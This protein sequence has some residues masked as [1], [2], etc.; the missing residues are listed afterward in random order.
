MINIKEE[1][2][3]LAKVEDFYSNNDT[4]VRSNFM[5]SSKYRSTLFSNR[6]MAISLSRLDH[7]KESSDGYLTVT[8]KGK[9]IQNML[10]V[11]SNNFFKELSKTAQG[12]TGQTIGWSSPETQEFEY[13]AV[14]TKATFKDGEF[15]VDFHKDIKHFLKDLKNSYTKLSLSVMLSFKS[16]YSFRLYELLRSKAYYKKGDERGDNLFKIEFDTNELRLDLGVVNAE[17]ESVRRV[18]NGKRGSDPEMWE[19][20]VAAS[21]EKTYSSWKDFKRFVLDKAVAEINDKPE[22]GLYIHKMEPK[23]AGRGGKVYG[24]T[25]YVEKNAASKKKKEAAVELNEVNELDLLDEI[26]EIVPGIKNTE[27]QKI[28]QAASWNLNLIR[29][30]YEIAR[31]QNVNNLVGWLIEAIKGDYQKPIKKGKII[32]PGFTQREYDYD[33]LQKEV[34]GR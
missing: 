10:D 14:V 15:T 31:T 33:A 25:F 32:D 30:K 21:P 22:T 5:I 28:G 11:K 23:K 13:I 20:A 24:V 16:T 6:L 4:Y 19:K 18:L 8:V 29:E 9:D 12:M 34:I 26:R 17:I 2:T 1:T 7:A 27:A 3:S